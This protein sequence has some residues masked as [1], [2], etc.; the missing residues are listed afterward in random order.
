MRPI[1]KS[2]AKLLGLRA[3]R[4]EEHARLSHSP[5][6]HH[7]ANTGPAHDHESAA[8]RRRNMRALMRLMHHSAVLLPESRRPRAGPQPGGHVPPPDARARA[9]RF[10]AAIRLT[11]VLGA[12]VNDTVPAAAFTN[13]NHTGAY[14][15][16]QFPLNATLSEV[17]ALR[18]AS[19][20]G[21]LA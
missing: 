4:T 13:A 7:Q 5:G 16:A 20:Q 21:A 1:T 2:V 3:L 11:S 8:A 10:P 18:G 12:T 6:K 9:A 19:L 14:G 15:H 17:G